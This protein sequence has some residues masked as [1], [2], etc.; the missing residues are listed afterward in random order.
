[1]LKI[2]SWLYFH[3]RF[4]GFYPVRFDIKVILKGQI[5]MLQRKTQ[6]YWL[7]FET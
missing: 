2:T 6:K 3:F 7:L 5:Y 4:E 1:M